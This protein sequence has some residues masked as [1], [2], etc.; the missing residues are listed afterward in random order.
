MVDRIFI[1]LLQ[2]SPVLSDLHLVL[3]DGVVHTQKLLLIY[4]IPILEEL[5]KSTNLPDN[6]PVTIFLP[7]I[8]R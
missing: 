6:D 4:S 5:I 2:D 1:K 7:G 8:S 3:D